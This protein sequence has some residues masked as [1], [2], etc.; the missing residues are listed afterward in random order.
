MTAPTYAELVEALDATVQRIRI[1]A[2]AHE[3]MG[4]HYLADSAN[5]YA[6]RYDALV[7][8]AKESTEV[9]A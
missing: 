7:K 4:H 9:S 8:A 2:R 5:S 6:N 1:E 3:Q